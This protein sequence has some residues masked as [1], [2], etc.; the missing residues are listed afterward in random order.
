MPC[1]IIVAERETLYR[2]VAQALIQALS[3]TLAERERATLALSGGQTPQPLYQLLAGA[4]YRQALDW[5]RVCFFW[6]DERY[7]PPT[8][9]LSNFRMVY[10][11]WLRDWQL[12]PDCLHPMPT[13]LPEPEEAARQY[14]AHLR[15][16]FGERTR[17]PHFDLILLGMGEDGHTASLF[18][19][20]LALKETTRWVV[21]VQAPI[22]PRQRLTLTLPVLNAARRVWFLVTGESKRDALRRVLQPSRTE[23]LL[24]AARVKPRRGELIWWVE[25]SLKDALPPRWLSE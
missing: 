22:E 23:P 1:R 25:E 3:E 11:L 6:A 15:E 16:L 12:P 2:Q 24:P 9:L 13:S 4:T 14:E 21:P 10:E 17:F 8:H 7:V 18:P 5:Q 20:D 19:D